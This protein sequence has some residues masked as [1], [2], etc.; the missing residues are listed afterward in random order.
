MR[1]A[2]GDFVVAGY[3][4]AIARTSGDYQRL[5]AR[6]ASRARRL[7][8]RDPEG[9]AQEALKRSLENPHSQPAMEY[10]FS[11]DP[12]ADLKN[13]EWPLDQLFA[14]LH[15]VVTYVVR[16]E[17]NRSSTRREVAFGSGEHLAEPVDPAAGQLAILIRRELEEIV[18]DSLPLLGEEYRTVL[19]MR[20]DGVK[21]GEIATLMGVSEN[22]VATWVSRGIRTL[23]QCVRKR[24]RVGIS[25]GRVSPGRVSND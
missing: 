21:Y 13:P 17:Q 7:G 12:P 11:Q 9:A 5:L 19:K 15:G 1:S 22:T 8:S 14:W 25:P 2:D 18:R 23:A 3:S 24:T 6:L 16:E 4:V 10:Y 20:A